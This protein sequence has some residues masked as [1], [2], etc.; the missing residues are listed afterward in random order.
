MF[1]GGCDGKDTRQKRHTERL[2]MESASSSSQE[3]SRISH[4]IKYECR[5]YDPGDRCEILD[6]ISDER[7]RK[8]L[9]AL[10][11]EMTPQE[12][13]DS[14]GIPLSTVYRKLEKMSETSL[15]TQGLRIETRGK[16]EPPKTFEAAFDKLTV[17]FSQDGVDLHVIGTRE[18]RETGS[19]LNVV[20]S[21]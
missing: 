13:S 1:V 6:I 4:A 17:A 19:G 12:I 21:P 18:E 2:K 15:V 16:G 8:I 7:S 5:S 20:G 3:G 9:A 14:C 10:E 11:D